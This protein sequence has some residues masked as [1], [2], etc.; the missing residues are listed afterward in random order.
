MSTF[1]FLGG[2]GVSLFAA[3]IGLW[4]A[5]KPPQVGIPTRRT[6]NTHATIMIVVTVLALANLAWRHADYH[7]ASVRRLASSSYQS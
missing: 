5:G 1:T 6:N 3:L 4:D 2:A 7:F